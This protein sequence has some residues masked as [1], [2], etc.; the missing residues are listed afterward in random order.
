MFPRSSLFSLKHKESL[1]NSLAV[2]CG[3]KGKARQGRQGKPNRCLTS[4]ESAAEAVL[5]GLAD[6]L[7]VGVEV[8][9][10][11][12]PRRDVDVADGVLVDVVQPFCHV[13]AVSNFAVNRPCEKTGGSV[14]WR[15]LNVR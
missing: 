8:V 10:E 15:L 2:E 9:H 7:E 11:R 5:V 13:G 6:W 12:L 1:R 4:H 3:G 14:G